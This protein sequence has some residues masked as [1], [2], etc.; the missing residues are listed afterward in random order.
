MWPF[1]NSSTMVAMHAIAVPDVAPPGS[2]IG[3]ALPGNR[4]GEVVAEVLRD[5]AAV[6]SFQLTAI[7]GRT[8]TVGKV[9]IALLVVAVG[10]PIAKAVMRRAALGGADPAAA[11]VA[12]HRLPD[13]PS[14]ANTR[15]P[16]TRKSFPRPR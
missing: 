16:A 13:T 7:D 3:T 6:W 15:S 11:V 2:V 12:T 8:L 14:T 5:F 4:I 1:V 9:V 10:A